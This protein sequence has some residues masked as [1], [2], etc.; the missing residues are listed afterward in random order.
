MFARSFAMFAL[1]ICSGVSVGAEPTK[2]DA[3]IEPAIVMGV[4]GAL[5]FEPDGTVSS[6]QI[7]TPLSPQLRP[8]V[9][10]TL[11]A[12]RFH[13]VVVDGVAR[14][15]RTGFDLQLVGRKVD[16]GYSVRVD[17]V[18]FRLPKDTP[19]LKELGISGRELHPPR[20]P[21]DAMMA[22]VSGRVVLG[23]RVTPDGTTGDVTV[24][25]SMLFGTMP[26]GGKFAQRYLKQL[27]DASLAAV[28]TWRYTVPSGVAVGDAASMTVLTP[29]EFKMG[30]FDTDVPGQWLPVMRQPTRRIPWMSDDAGLGDALGGAAGSLASGSNPIRLLTPAAGQPVM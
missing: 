22:G 23:I 4:S 24:V 21:K 17:G 30:E 15:A 9:E 7:D 8:S 1:F 16:A 14:Q 25:R 20:Y 18:D 5:V 3:G 13:P 26:R 6:L 2:P 19:N 11:R 27:E 12:W 28:R 29:M 10:R